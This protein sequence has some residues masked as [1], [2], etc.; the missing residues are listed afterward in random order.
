MIVLQAGWVVPVDGPPLRDAGVAVRDGTV[1][2][3][4]PAA[5][6]PAGEVRDLGAGVLLPGL[7]NAHCHLELSHLAGRLGEATGFVDWVERLVA[8]RGTDSAE[9]VRAAAARAIEELEATGT[10]AVGDVSNGLSH[11]DLLARSSLRARVFFELIGWDPAAAARILEGAQAR[12][13]AL[14]PGGGVEVSL[15][16]HAPHSV[17]AP[18]LAALAGAGGAS[19]L[20]LAESPHESRFLDG[21]D[22]E[23]SAFLARRGLGH[24]PFVAPHLSPVR[25]VDGLGV[26]RPGLVAAHGVQVDAADGALLA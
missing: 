18:L 13:R 1:Q 4:G 2:W 17:S 21:G 7:V 22:P 11:L 12:L 15:A 16:A 8:A 26:L 24:V 6:A 19:A 9:T 3:V 20:H 25:Y 5:Q 14:D 10:V 23:W